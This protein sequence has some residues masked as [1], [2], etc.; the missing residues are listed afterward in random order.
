MRNKIRDLKFLSQQKKK[1]RDFSYAERSSIGPGNWGNIH[2]D[3]VM[4][5]DG[6]V[7]FPIDIRRESV[8]IQSTLGGLNLNYLASN[9]T[10][11]N[12]VHTVKERTV[13]ADQ[14]ELLKEVVNHDFKS[15]ARPVQPLNGRQINAR[16]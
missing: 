2:G 15:N 16:S 9:A 11:E 8:Q 1:M 4:C 7:Q 3:W 6:K 13:S 10:I 12:K 14:V 5:R